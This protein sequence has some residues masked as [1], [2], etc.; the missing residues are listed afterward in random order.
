M[1]LLLMTLLF[2]MVSVLTR[3]RNPKRKTFAYAAAR[4]GISEPTPDEEAIAR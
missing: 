3:K 1:A 4:Y 2:V